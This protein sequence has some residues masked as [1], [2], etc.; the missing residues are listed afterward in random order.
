MPRNGWEGGTYNNNN[1]H[2][3]LML[4][5][6]PC[7]TDE[8]CR[9]AADAAGMTL[10]GAHGGGARRGARRGGRGLVADEVRA[11]R[12]GRA[13]P[14]SARFVS[15]DESPPQAMRWHSDAAAVDED[16]APERL[17]GAERLDHREPELAELAGRVLDALLGARLDEQLLRR[18][19]DR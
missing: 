8:N 5:T 3:V 2:N 12:C 4:C 13:R 7:E 19:I 18:S 9:A 17:C 6:T 11:T 1:D 16:L 14:A 15:D 10:R